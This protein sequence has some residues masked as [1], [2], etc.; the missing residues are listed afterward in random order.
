MRNRVVS[1]SCTSI[2]WVILSPG[3]Q[4]KCSHCTTCVGD[5]TM[6]SAPLFYTLLLGGLLWLCF[7]LHVAWPSEQGITGPLTPKPAQHPVS[8]PATYN[9]LQVSPASPIATP[10]SKRSQ[11][12]GFRFLRLR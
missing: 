3:N 12:S 9:R 8:A 5:H 2:L 4:V 7:I 10:V 6:L 11:A 1:R